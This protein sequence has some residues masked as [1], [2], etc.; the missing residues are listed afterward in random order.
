MNYIKSILILLVFTIII[1]PAFS[2]IYPD[3]NAK[4]ENININLNSAGMFVINYDLLETNLYDLYFVTVF[5]YTSNKELI[6]AETLSGDIN[7]GVSGGNRKKIVW[8]VKKDI[9]ILEGNIYVEIEARLTNPKIIKPIKVTT[10]LAMSTLYPGWGG[11]RIT[12]NSSHLYKGIAG[13]GSIGAAIYLNNKSVKTYDLYQSE[14]DPIE[15]EAIYKK[16]ETQRTSSRIM[17]AGAVLIWLS[18]YATVIFSENQV[19]I[20][21]QKSGKLSLFPSVNIIGEAPC[22]SLNI[23]F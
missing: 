12:R 9:E 6:H 7:D 20:L 15:R 14:T 16:F 23:K 19:P 21:T 13:Y 1:N 17:I 11:Y 22:L 8:D 18:D 10:G 4:V 2:Q 3:C 5:I